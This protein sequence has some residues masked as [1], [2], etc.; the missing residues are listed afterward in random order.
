MYKTNYKMVFIT[1]AEWKTRA[2]SFDKN[3]KYELIND[4]EYI[5]NQGSQGLAEELFGNDVNVE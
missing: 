5:N 4:D 3:K 2:T 1:D